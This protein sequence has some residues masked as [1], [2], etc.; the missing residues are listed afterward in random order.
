[1]L[2]RR[3][4]DLTAEFREIFE[5]GAEI[6]NVFFEPVAKVLVE[7][8]QKTDNHEANGGKH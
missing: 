3:D 2:F 1:M 8:L 4:R 6:E 5:E 7:K